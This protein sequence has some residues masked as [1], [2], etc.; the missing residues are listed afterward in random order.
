MKPLLTLSLAAVVLAGCATAYVEWTKTGN[1]PSDLATAKTDCE[2]KLRQVAHTFGQYGYAQ[3][4]RFV[5]TCM[6]SHG[7]SGHWVQR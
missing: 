6:A 5:F 2:F 7:F 4:E 1:S 3:A